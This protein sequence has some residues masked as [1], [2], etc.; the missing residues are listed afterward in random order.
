MSGWLGCGPRLNPCRASGA[1]LPSL[2][3]IVADYRSFAK[4]RALEDAYWADPRIDF[5]T[6]I[7]R[8]C[9]SIDRQN[10]RHSHQRRIPAHVLKHAGQTLAPHADELRSATDFD[11]LHEAVERLLSDQLG[12]GPVQIYDFSARIGLWAG[13]HPTRVYLHAGVR[14][15]AHNLGLQTVDRQW[16]ALSEMPAPLCDLKAAEV[17]DILCIYKANFKNIAR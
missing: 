9:S 2:E 13:R 7:H 17:E 3:A 1:P 12:V 8:A 16:L 11:A 10:K 15:G 6:A 14:I 4:E 5:T